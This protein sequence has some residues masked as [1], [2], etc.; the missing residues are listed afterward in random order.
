MKKT[1][2]FLSLLF[3]LL[4]FGTYGQ[5]PGDTKALASNETSKGRRELRKETRV[6]KNERRNLDKQEK[7]A[8]K[9]AK[10][11]IHKK[12]LNTKPKRRHKNK[13]KGKNKKEPSE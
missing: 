6:K 7:R 11:K 8:V 3:L 5:G 4:S 13:E 9:S 10:H 1:I 2:T 12:T